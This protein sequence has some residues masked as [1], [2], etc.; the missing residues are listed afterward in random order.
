MD[1][2]IA[3]RSKESD[4][5]IKAVMK[6]VNQSAECELDWKIEHGGNAIYISTDCNSHIGNVVKSFHDLLETYQTLDIRASYSYSCRE[7]DG[8][9]DWWESVSI[10]TETNPDG[11]KYLR[12]SSSTYWN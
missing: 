4:S 9:A 11:S 5:I 10:S 1:I 3:C 2:T 8:S 12:E 7:D 6:Q